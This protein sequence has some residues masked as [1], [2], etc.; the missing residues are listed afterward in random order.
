MN[1]HILSIVRRSHR[2]ARR[3][4]KAEDLLGPGACPQT[5]ESHGEQRR[6]GPSEVRGR[7]VE[8][9]PLRTGYRSG[10][11][12]PDNRSTT[13]RVKHRAPAPDCPPVRVAAEDALLLRA[14]FDDWLTPR[15]GALDRKGFRFEDKSVPNASSPMRRDWDRRRALWPRLSPHGHT[16]G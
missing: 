8:P 12:D 13:R 3:P 6:N 5:P 2:S 9:W 16:H 11:T 1:R 10:S 7:R 14:V 15:S 4:H